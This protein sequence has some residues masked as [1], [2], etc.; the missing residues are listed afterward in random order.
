VAIF[1]KDLVSAPRAFAERLFNV[2]RWT[3]MPHGGHFAALEE[4]TLLA[5]GLRRFFR[6]LRTSNST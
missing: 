5:E 2:Q 4:P 6:P 1:P 3:Q